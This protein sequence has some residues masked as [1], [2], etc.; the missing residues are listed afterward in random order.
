MH[1]QWL[2]FEHERLHEVEGWP[3]GP[4]K[5]ATLA[6]I[7]S[8]MAMLKLQAPDIEQPHC[9]ACSTRLAPVVVIAPPVE[10]SGEKS[11]SVAA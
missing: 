4:M 3:D 7:R 11:A 10:D 5:E 9:L 6:A 2:W 8:T 1:R